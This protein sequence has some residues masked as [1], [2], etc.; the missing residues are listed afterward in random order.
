MEVEAGGE[1]DG[2]EHAEVVFGKAG[3]GVADGADDTGGEVGSAVDKVEDFACDGI[4]EEAV[5]REV[6]ALCVGGGVS[7]VLDRFRTAAVGVG[8]VCAVGGDFYAVDEHDTEV[9]TD[10]NGVGEEAGDVGGAG[11]GGDIVVLRGDTEEEVADASADE[12][13]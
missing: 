1:A 11:A 4:E 9:G 3:D 2:A 12:P 6:A 5:D 7:F 8:A 13:G 10:G